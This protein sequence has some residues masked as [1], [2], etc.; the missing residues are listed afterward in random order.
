[1]WRHDSLVFLNHIK[2][3]VE[4]PRGDARK[5]L[6]SISDHGKGLTG[7]CLTVCEDADVVAVHSWLDQI[8]MEEKKNRKNNKQ[9]ELKTAGSIEN[10]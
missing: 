9:K 1:M 5:V 2:Y 3:L 4:S 8:L 6:L 10:G 7:T